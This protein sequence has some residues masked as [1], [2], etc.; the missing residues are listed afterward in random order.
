MDPNTRTAIGYMTT[1]HLKPDTCLLVVSKIDHSS[2]I[3]RKDCNIMN[4]TI[5]LTVT[6]IGIRVV[7]GGW[8]S[9]VLTIQI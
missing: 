4:I 3:L 1:I 6:L 9:L 2:G 8:K 5:C 7:L